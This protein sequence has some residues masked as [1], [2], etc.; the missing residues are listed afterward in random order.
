M[1]TI[2]L[3]VGMCRDIIANS[4]ITRAYVV[5][6]CNSCNTDVDTLNAI[7]VHYSDCVIQFECTCIVHILYVYKVNKK[8]RKFEV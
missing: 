4:H 6:S 5:N 3:K 7:H 2:N 8:F 1:V